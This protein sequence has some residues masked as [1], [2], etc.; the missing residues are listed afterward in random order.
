MQRR[1]DL[2]P[3][4]YEPV[5]S[6]V[7]GAHEQHELQPPHGQIEPLDVIGTDLRG[8]AGKE[9]AQHRDD[10]FPRGRSRESGEYVM[11]EPDQVVGLV[12]VGPVT[13][14]RVVPERVE[15]RCQ[16]LT[17]RVG[18]GSCR[19]GF[20]GV[21]LV[22]LVQLRLVR[23]A[24]GPAVRRGRREPFAEQLLLEGPGTEVLDV[25][26]LP[27]LG[28]RDQQ[29]VQPV[30]RRVGHGQRGGPPLDLLIGEGQSALLGEFFDPVRLH[31]V[32]P[33]VD[34]GGD[35]GGGG[36]EDL[37]QLHLYR[38]CLVHEDH[39]TADQGEFQMPQPLVA[40][41]PGHRGLYEACRVGYP[42]QGVHQLTGR[43]VTRADMPQGAA[44]RSSAQFGR[45][46][47]GEPGGGPA[48]PVGLG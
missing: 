40:Q 17:H 14:E 31:L 24:V 3:E 34:A 13:A 1:L 48:G 16:L 36:S 10:P 5:K 23:H 46:R 6:L 41:V 20:R 29:L 33:G 30:R 28:V 15:K 8:S 11:C 21:I 4:E 18:D 42:D 25:R 19:F 9:W 47:L 32:Q 39:V 12:G 26:P 2:R 37:I 44:V 45:P 22:R 43:V 38:I 7:Q 35:E 27:E